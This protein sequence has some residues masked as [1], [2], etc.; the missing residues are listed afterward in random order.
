MEGHSTPPRRLSTE[1]ALVFT[2][3][4]LAA[5]AR[6]PVTPTAALPHPVSVAPIPALPA[7]PPPLPLPAPPGAG[8]SYSVVVNDVPVREVLFALARD[9]G[10]DLDLKGE[11]TTRITL[12]AVEQPLPKLV[13]RIANLADLR[14]SLDGGLLAVA[15]D[16]PYFHSY[17]VAYVNLRRDTETTVNIATQV[18]TTGEGGA[19]AAANGGGSANSSST[20][21]NSR[22]SH[23]FWPTLAANVLALI[24]EA[25]PAGAELPVSPAL[26]VNPEA[27]VLAVKATQRQHAQI[28]AFIEQVLANAR[29]QVLVEATV[30]EVGLNDRYQTGVDW[31]LVLDRAR[32]GLSG[33]QG[34]LGAVAEGASTLTLGYRDPDSNGRLIEATLQLLHDYGDTRVLSS[35]RLM[36]LNNQTALLKVVE[37]LVYFTVEV[38]ATDG[39]ANAQGRTLVQ[40]D[41]HSVPV[42]LV[43]TVT[44]QVSADGEVTLTVRP[45]ISQKIGDA[46]DPGPQLAVSLNGQGRTAPANLVPIIRTRE[47]ESV[48]RLA[49]GQVGVLGGLMQDDVQADTRE[50]PGLGQLPG[51]GRW[52]FRSETRKRRKSELVIFLRPVVVESPG[53]DGDLR[54][55]RRW[56]SPV[57]DARG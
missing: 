25:V 37:E 24:G 2:A 29:R 41:V 15:A 51:L 16:E 22:A 52:L 31:K 3:L 26:V 27:G 17:D 40:S 45:T 19:K 7:A 53:L 54:E 34:L 4:A 9:A 44:P 18:A 21:V 10:L 35:P 38:T 12:N 48:L 33:A 11:F 6:Q 55:Y 36:V 13:R 57:G 8:K 30:V 28:A 56:Q 14:Y 46:V 1:A 32:A 47:M 49:N 42:G 43:M 50:V 23:H 20:R 39:T 5:C